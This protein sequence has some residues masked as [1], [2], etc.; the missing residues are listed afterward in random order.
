MTYKL[1]LQFIASCTHR[2]VF[3]VTVDAMD[4]FE[5]MLKLISLACR[6]M[7]VHVHWIEFA[8]KQEKRTETSGK[9]IMYRS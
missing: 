7:M 3:P 8:A 2:G 1:L 9:R 6:L 4:V 5:L